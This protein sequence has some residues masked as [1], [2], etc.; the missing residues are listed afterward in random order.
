[1]ESEKRL[2]NDLMTKIRNYLEY[3]GDYDVILEITG[4]SEE[5]LALF[6]QSLYEKDI[7]ALEII[8]EEIQVGINRV[9]DYD[10]FMNL[11]S[12][13]L[14]AMEFISNLIFRGKNHWIRK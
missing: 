8:Y 1:M 4:G 5:G 14:K 3:F 10:Q 7:P 12:S 2:R 11:F 6:K 9:K 13:T